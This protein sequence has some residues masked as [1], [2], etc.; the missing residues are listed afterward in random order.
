MQYS[1]PFQL[2]CYN[3][4]KKEWPKGGN[5]ILANYD[6]SSIIVYQAFNER[7]AKQIVLNQNY[8]SEGCAAS[9]VSMNRMTWIKPNFLWMMYRSGWSTKEGQER[10]LAIRITRSGFEEILS[11]AAISRKTEEREP[12][13]SDLVRLQWDPDREPNGDKVDSGRRAI[14]LG[15][16]GEAFMKFS[17]EFIL[18]IDDITDFV[19]EMREHIDNGEMLML[20]IERVYTVEDPHISQNILLSSK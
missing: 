4:Q 1:V 17:R 16:R 3:H 12:T 7:A 18:K 6:E 13:K 10:V 2:T 14:Q 11:K 8:H 9:G 15:L 19:T 20:P 5:V